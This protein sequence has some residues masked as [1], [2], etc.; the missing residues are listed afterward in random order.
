MGVFQPFTGMPGFGSEKIAK[1]RTVSADG[2]LQFLPG[3]VILDGSKMRDPDNPDYNAS[4]NP[5]AQLQLRP[6]LLIG[7][8]TSGSK[9]ANSV[10]GTSSGALTGSATTLTLASAQQGVELARRVGATGTFKLTGPPTASGTVR[11]ATVTYS[12]ISGADVTITAVGVSDVWTL[13]APAGQDAGFYQLEVT[14][15]LG[16]SAEATRTT[17]ALAA[18]ANSATVDAAL[19]ALTNVGASGVVAVYADPTLTLTF[20]SNLGPVHVRVVSDTTNDGGAFEGGWAAVHTTTGVD[21]RFVTNSLIQPTDG[22]ETIR[23]FL[24]DGW[25]LY[26]PLDGTDM[27]LNHLPIEGNVDLSKLLPYPADA[28]TIQWIRDQLNAYGKFVFTEKY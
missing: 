2:Y 20:A 17:A 23:S 16:T 13:T 28:S 24:P 9:W 15:G 27:P 4:T 6:G 5:L 3:G 21:G 8:V 19:E 7:K 22:S 10:I 12:G 14:T 1:H 25:E 18:N 26:M 11:T